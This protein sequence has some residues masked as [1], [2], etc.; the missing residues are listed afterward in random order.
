M[1]WNPSDVVRVFCNEG[2]DP[3]EVVIVLVNAQS[4]S[5]P[6]TF[7]QIIQQPLGL[8]DIVCGTAAE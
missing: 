5:I 1:E 8:P 3:Q 7:Y 4:F 6:Y 2:T